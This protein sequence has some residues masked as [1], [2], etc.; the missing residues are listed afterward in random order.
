MILIIDLFLFS[1]SLKPTYYTNHNYFYSIVVS[2][3][4]V[5][6]ATNG[7]IVAYNYLN[8]TYRILT[9]TDGLPVNRQKC[10]ALDSAGNLWAGSN[11]GLI[12]INQAFNH[13]QSYPLECLPCTRINTICCL[14]DTILVGTE[15]GLLVIDTKGTLENFQDDAI[16]KIYDYQGLSSNNIQTIAVETDFWIGTDYKI[17]RFTRDFINYYIYGIENGI[18]SNNIKKI[19]II[20]TDIFVG[21]DAGLNMFTGSY[22]DTLLSGYKIN[23]IAPAGDSLL[24]ALDSILQTGILFQGSLTIINDSIPYLTRINDVETFNGQWFSGS[25]NRYDSDYFGEGIG[26]Y[27]HSNHCWRLKKDNCLGSNHISSITA[28]EYGIFVGH[29]RR[30]IE[31]RGLSW[32]TTEDKWKN[33]CQDSFIPTKYIHRCVTSPDKKVWFAFHYT[34]SLIA[35]S[36]DPRN[37]TWFYLRQKYEGMDSSVAIWDMKF[38]LHN[39]MYLSLAGP[40]DKIWVIDSSLSNVYFLGD[41]TPGFE[42]E[43]AI[44]SSL[45]IWSTVFDAAG[46]VLMIDTKG[47]IFD[48]GDDTNMKYGKSDGLLSHYCSGVTVDEDNTLYIAND[49]GIAVF[50]NHTFEGVEGFGGAGVYDVLADG[51]GRVWIMAANGIYYYDTH[52]KILKGFPFNDLNVNIEFLSLGNEIIQVQGFFYDRLR[53]CFW[54]GGETGLLKLEIIKQDTL[55]LDSILIYPNPVVQGSILRIKNISANAS[56]NIYSISGRSVVK[57][58]KPNSLGE[59]LWRI[60]NDIPSGLYFALVNSESGKKVCKFAIVK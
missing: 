44:D 34:D 18:L 1:I 28:N 51:E 19:E 47:T 38:D 5:Y 24:L 60:P 15:N 17:T 11:A 46:G 41:R 36:F 37:D 39:N 9:N 22:F 54:L 14:N 55:P 12:Q 57:G 32:L 10:I 52:Y 29:G 8:N 16:L 13:V 35:C 33:F 53:S 3:S 30:T 6:G 23:D 31:S 20:G 56:V 50:R 7:G 27:D 40:S 26:V 48:R 2:D 21:T 4:L 49:I 45:R 25:G 43:L 42:V 59:I 58:L